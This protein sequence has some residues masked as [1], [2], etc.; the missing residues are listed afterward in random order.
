MLPI[1]SKSIGLISDSHG[2]ADMIEKAIEFLHKQHCETIIHLGDICDSFRPETCETCLDV[3]NAH[4]IIALKGNNDHILE[5][6]Q[7]ENNDAILTPNGLAYLSRLSPV[8]E[9]NDTVFAHSLPFYK[10]L[11]ISCITRFL[12]ETEIKRFLSGSRH[13]LLFRGHGHDPEI[14]W[15]KNGD[16]CCKS[17]EAGGETHLNTYQPCI[18]TC[19]ALTRGLAMIWDKRNNVLKNLSFL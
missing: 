7:T 5:I 8:L 12:G 11:G 13:T 3:L 4:N 9:E 18:V 16:I 10:E 15:K 14:I 2:Q 19:G 17:I 1:G 6:N